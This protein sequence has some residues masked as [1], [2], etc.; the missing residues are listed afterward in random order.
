MWK[1]ILDLVP[2]PSDRS[3][4]S[5]SAPQRRNLSSCFL[6]GDRAVWVC[7]SLSVGSVVPTGSL[8]VKGTSPLTPCHVKKNQQQ[9]PAFPQQV[10]EINTKTEN[11]KLK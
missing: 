2:L 9:K 4:D 5:I 1:Q 10:K 6:F 7:L 3:P 11:K 8:G